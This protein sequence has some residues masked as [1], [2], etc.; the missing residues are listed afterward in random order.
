MNKEQIK[1]RQIKTVND[2]INFLEDESIDWKNLNESF[3]DPN[4]SGFWVPANI[5]NLPD[6]KELEQKAPAIKASELNRTTMTASEIELHEKHNYGNGYDRHQPD[7]RFLKIASL[8]GFENT[9]VWI[10]NQPP[11]AMMARHV[12][13]ISCLVHE[14]I[15]TIRH[16]PFDLHM[17]QPK[18]AKPIYRCFVALDDWHPGQILNFEPDFWT[19][20]KKGDVCFFHWRT[21]AHSTAN[22]GWHHRPLLKITGT[23]KD[24]AW[25]NGKIIR[26][27]DYND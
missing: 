25:L 3:I 16:E 19:G 10:N 20:W 9:S 8:L 13:T 1:W 12:D 22:T 14:Q 26:S 23:L 11:G 6:A 17:R 15:D 21:T 2:Y 27:F 4:Q 5:K 24:D 18:N 7:E